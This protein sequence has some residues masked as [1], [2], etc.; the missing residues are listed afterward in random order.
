MSAKTTKGR[1]KTGATTARA[2]RT[3]SSNGKHVPGPV[4]L[5]GETEEERE[6]RLA[7]RRALTLKVFHTAYESHQRRKAS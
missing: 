6:K 3:A 5:E 1:E 4:L 7:K 2:P